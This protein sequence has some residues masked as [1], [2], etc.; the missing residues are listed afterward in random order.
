M[1]LDCLNS[2]AGLTKFKDPEAEL[3][4]IALK[5]GELRLLNLFLDQ[6]RFDE[7]K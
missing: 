6:Q 4:F 2:K 1:V 3:V 5:S 7:S